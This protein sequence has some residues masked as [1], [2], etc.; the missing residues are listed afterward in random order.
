MLSKVRIIFK[1]TTKTSAERDTNDV[2]SEGRRDEPSK[3][4]RRRRVDLCTH[5]ETQTQTQTQKHQ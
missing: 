1:S 2:R 4:S 3:A 5:M